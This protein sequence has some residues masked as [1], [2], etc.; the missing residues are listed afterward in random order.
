M[1]LLAPQDWHPPRDHTMDLPSQNNTIQRQRSSPS[2]DPSPSSA[3]STPP[4]QPTPPPPQQQPYPYPV[5][6]QPQGGWTPSIAA[7]PFYPSFYQNPNQQQ[8]PYNLH[9]HPPHS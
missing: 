3:S 7:Q 8:Q 6:Q 5:Q 4:Q 9:G 2:N 1:A